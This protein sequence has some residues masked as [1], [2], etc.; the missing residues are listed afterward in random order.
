MP[1]R[2][3]AKAGKSAEDRLLESSSDSST[4]NDISESESVSDFDENSNN[5]SNVAPEQLNTTSSVFREAVEKAVREQ[6]ILL[7]MTQS[8]SPQF[9]ARDF[10]DNEKLVG[11]KN[12]K[13]WKAT[14]EM[15]LKA[16]GLLRYV[17]SSVLDPLVAKEV[18]EVKKAQT[19]IL[20]RRSVVK[21]IANSIGNLHTPFAK[22]HRMNILLNYSSFINEEYNV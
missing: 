19:L 9:Y 22:L 17:E 16:L 4:C 7:N 2:K 15:E 10:E 1:N 11:Y 12:F 3:V 13:P 8:S 5:Q 20:L 18:H 14:V 21:S 6:M